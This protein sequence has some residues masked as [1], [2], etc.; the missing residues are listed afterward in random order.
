MQQVNR[1]LTLSRIGQY[2]INIK[3]Q[4]RYKTVDR[5]DLI[6]STL[7]EDIVNNGLRT[8]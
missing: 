1:C 8:I 4:I 6:L 3:F 5:F 7:M 2:H